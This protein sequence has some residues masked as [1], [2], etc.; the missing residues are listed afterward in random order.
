MIANW[1][2]RQGGL[3]TIAIIFITSPIVQLIIMILTG[4]RILDV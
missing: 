1:M 3:R 2:S 4:G